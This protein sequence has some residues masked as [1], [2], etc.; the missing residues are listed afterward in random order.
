MTQTIPTQV[1]GQRAPALGQADDIL[2]AQQPILDIDQQLVAYELL[3]RGDFDQVDGYSASA[4]VFLNA[5][6]Q[7][8]FRS[9]PE[10]V[11]MFV[12]FT[13]D[14]L[15]NLPPFDTDSF[16]IELLET[17]EPTPEVVA[18]VRMLKE[19]GYQLALDDFVYSEA[20]I[21]L[22]Q[23]ADIVKVDVMETSAQEVEQLVLILREYGVTLLAEKVEDHETFERCKALGFEWYQGYFFARPKLVEGKVMGPN[24]SAVLSMVTALQQPD[25]DMAALERI[26]SSD[27]GLTYKVLR[28][29]NNAAIRRAVP[30]DTVAKAVSML[31]LRRLQNFATLMALSELPQK[32]PELQSYT[33]YR[34]M[35]CERIGALLPTEY[36][37]EL[38]QLVGILSCCDAY[39]DQALSDLITNLPLSDDVVDALLAHTGHLGAVLH[40]AIALQEGRWQQVDWPALELVGVRE[41]AVLEVVREVTAWAS[42]VS[43]DEVW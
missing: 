16:V 9:G 13:E 36:P 41:S 31:G 20:Q 21:P 8:H 29:S 3:F 35:L 34:G 19:H 10:A 39:F 40:A 32:P 4:R 17:I 28:L 5:F 7:G 33:A 25:L 30:I 12:N 27:T 23:C 37:A 1:G 15:F 42:G 26:I 22:L 6:D 38:F 14:L 43:G 11:P 24:K 18:Q 2:F